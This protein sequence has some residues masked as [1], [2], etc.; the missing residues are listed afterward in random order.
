MKID[1]TSK[2][3]F[4]DLYTKDTDTHNYLHYTSAHP[5]Q[6]KTGGPFGEFLRIR[7]NCHK[8][9]DFE[10]HANARMTDCIRRGYP[11][12]DIERAKDKARQTTRETALLDKK[13][14]KSKNLRIPLILTFNPAYPNMNKIIE[15][16]WH[17]IGKCINKV[18]F[19]EKPLI[20]Y[21]RNTNLSDKLVRCGHF[22][23]TVPSARKTDKKCKKPWMC[24]FCLKP[25]YSRVYKSTVTGR[26]YKG[27]ATY[28]CKTKNVIYLITCKKCKNNILEKHTENLISE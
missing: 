26:E 17:L 8:L 22:D 2:T 25:P 4:T 6:C 3:V 28:T 21:R 19:L 15:K 7:R 18:V 23:R 5:A 11:K 1:K 27:P 13:H 24:Q 14:T 16:H 10:S 20:T 12:T 9:T